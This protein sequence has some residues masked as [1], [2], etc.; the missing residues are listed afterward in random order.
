[1]IF[2]VPKKNIITLTGLQMQL[3]VTYVG[4]FTSENL[5]MLEAGRSRVRFPTRCLNFFQFLFPFECMYMYSL[6]IKGD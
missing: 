5:S 3:G 6:Q 2:Q 4:D 1:M